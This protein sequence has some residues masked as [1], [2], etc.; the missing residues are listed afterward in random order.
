MQHIKFR[1]NRSTSS[2]EDVEG[3]LPYN[4]GMAAVLVM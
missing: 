1:G 2:G 3:L 4:M